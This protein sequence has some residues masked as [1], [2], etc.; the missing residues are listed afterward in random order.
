VQIKSDTGIV[1]SHSGNGGQTSQDY[2]PT[3]GQTPSVKSPP[4]SSRS[5]EGVDTPP[6]SPD[7]T[8]TVKGA[9]PRDEIE[10]A[11]AW[12]HRSRLLCR[13]RRLGS[14]RAAGE[15]AAHIQQSERFRTFLRRCRAYVCSTG[16]RWPA[17]S[18]VRRK[19][20]DDRPSTWSLS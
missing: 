8:A 7:S 10:A 6:D 14:L 12:D 2:A 16:K 13:R 18:A 1:E 19:S 15:F 9:A 11:L 3:D 4:P 20:T 17:A 5:R